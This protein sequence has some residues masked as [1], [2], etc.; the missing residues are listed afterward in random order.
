MKTQTCCF[1]GHRKI[2]PE[3]YD[4]I[5]ERLRA[6][7][8]TLIQNGI[9][10]FG[11]GGALGFDTLAALTVLSLQKEHPR[12]RLI[13]VLPCPTQAH[14]WAAKDIAIARIHAQLH[15]PPK[16]PPCRQQQRLPLLSDQNQRR[17]GIHR[18]VCKAERPA[19]HQPRKPVTTK[20]TLPKN[21]FGRVFSVPF[22]T[23]NTKSRFRVKPGMTCF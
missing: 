21:P 5:A 11:A 6:E 7:I 16:P 3:Q 8:I 19:S 4:C 23:S 2:P 12:I 14:S 17:H 10:F 15:A 1:T 18:G 22:I 13:L 9:T 20:N